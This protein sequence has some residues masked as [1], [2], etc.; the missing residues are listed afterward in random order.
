MFKCTCRN[1]TK[2][3]RVQFSD[4]KSIELELEWSLVHTIIGKVKNI[5]RPGLR[6]LKYYFGNVAY[7]PIEGNPSTIFQP[8]KMLLAKEAEQS[9]SY[10]R[11]APL[12]G[13]G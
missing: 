5:S 1:V 10:S 2:N 12:Y 3:A 8:P 4:P 13:L 11:A 6:S 9:D 7:L